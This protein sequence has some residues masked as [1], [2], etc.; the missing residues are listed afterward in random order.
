LRDRHADLAGTGVKYQWLGAARRSWKGSFLIPGRG[1]PGTISICTRNNSQVKRH[2][3][4]Q[5]TRNNVLQFLAASLTNWLSYRFA[6]HR[7]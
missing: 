3:P 2:I 7:G 6:F 5:Q 1:A 4:L